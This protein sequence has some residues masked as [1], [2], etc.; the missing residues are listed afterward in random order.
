MSIE[1]IRRF[2]SDKKL[3]MTVHGYNGIDTIWLSFDQAQELVDDLTEMLHGNLIQ[4][5]A[6]DCG[7]KMRKHERLL[8]SKIVK[9]V[10]REQQTISEVI[11]DVAGA[12]EQL[13][14]EVRTL[15]RSMIDSG[16]L[17]LKR[18][19]RLGVA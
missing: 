8:E 5:N 7:C 1:A 18:N 3:N 6:K 10:Q 13:R 16:T 11:C 9:S 19:W 2:K 17:K 15:I 4:V 12:D 14:S